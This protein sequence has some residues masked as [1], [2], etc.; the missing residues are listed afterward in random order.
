MRRACRRPR[1]WP[2]CSQTAAVE[3]L[4][5]RALV[6][7]LEF[8]KDAE[9]VRAEFLHALQSLLTQW[10]SRRKEELIARMAEDPSARGEYA[11]LLE[12]ESRSRA[13]SAVV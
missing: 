7:E 5:R 6:E 11:A 1:P 2:K 10:R 9:I 8:E 12:E 4:L 3:P 13:L